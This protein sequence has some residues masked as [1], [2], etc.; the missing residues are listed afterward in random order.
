MAQ[1]INQWSNN[2]NISS[3]SPCVSRNGQLCEG[4]LKGRFKTS[5]MVQ[6]YNDASLTQKNDGLK[7]NIQNIVRPVMEEVDNANDIHAFNRSEEEGFVER[8]QCHFRIPDIPRD[9]FYGL[10]TPVTKE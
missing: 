6:E 5:P 1:L 10:A 4:R 8:F 3:S 9:A 7:H 2:D